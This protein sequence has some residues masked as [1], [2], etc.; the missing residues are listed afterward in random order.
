MFSLIQD[1]ELYLG[2]FLST[3]LERNSH[4]FFKNLCGL[5]FYVQCLI[6][7]EFI[8]HCKPRTVLWAGWSVAGVDYRWATE[9]NEM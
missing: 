5:I 3:R 2:M 1:F 4:I 7:L 9:G 6:T 8:S